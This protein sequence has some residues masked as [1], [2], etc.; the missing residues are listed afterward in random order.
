MNHLIHGLLAPPNLFCPVPPVLARDTASYLV[1]Q[2]GNI[3][4]LFK[5]SLSLILSYQFPR[6]LAVFHVSCFYLIPHENTLA[7]TLTHPSPS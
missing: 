6:L 1:S 4:I 3:S 7:L 2:A 5:L